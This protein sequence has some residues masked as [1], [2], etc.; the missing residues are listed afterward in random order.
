MKH[1]IEVLVKAILSF[2]KLEWI[3]IFATLCVSI[4]KK[5]VQ[6]NY[7]TNELWFPFS[8][9]RSPPGEIL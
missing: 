8:S 3:F 5:F 6:I 1:E 2:Q 7:R 4:A 9:F